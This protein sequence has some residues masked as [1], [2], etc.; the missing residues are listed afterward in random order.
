[1]SHS[2]DQHSRSSTHLDPDS[3]WE[4]VRQNAQES[5]SRNEEHFS[6]D[7]GRSYRVLEVTA[8]KITVERFGRDG[9]PQRK[10]LTRNTVV[11]MIEILNDHPNGC[12]RSTLHETYYVTNMLIDLHPRLVLRSGLVCVV[13]AEAAGDSTDA[14]AGAEAPTPRPIVVQ[15]EAVIIESMGDQPTREGDRDVTPQQSRDE[16]S[17][18]DFSTLDRKAKGFQP[19]RLLDDD[20]A[21]PPQLAEKYEVLE[22]LGRGGMGQ[23]WKVRDRKLG[24]IVALKLIRGSLTRDRKALNRFMT[25]ARSA[26]ALNH[27]NVVQLYELDENVPYLT[28]E[29]AERGDLNRRLNEKGPLSVEEAVKLTVQLADALR[30]AHTHP[31]R[32]RHRDIKPA[33]VLLAIGQQGLMIPKLCDFGLARMESAEGH[34]SSG[35]IV[36]TPDYMAPE[37][38]QSAKQ[39]SVL[40]DQW[41]L[42]ATLYAMLTGKSPRYMRES[43]IPELVREVVSKGLEDDPKDRFADV[44]AFAAA[45]AACLRESRSTGTESSSEFRRSDSTS[46]PR[47]SSGLDLA[48][49]VRQ[50]QESADATHREARRLIESD[51]DYSVAAQLLEDIPEHLRDSALFQRA[52]INRDRVMELENSIASAVGAMNLNGLDGQVEELLALQPDRDDMQEL[53]TTLPMEFSCPGCGHEM[54]LQSRVDPQRQARCRKCRCVFRI[55]DG[56]ITEAAPVTSSRS[57]SDS[58]PSSET[59]RTSHSGK[60]PE[61]LKSPFSADVAARSQQEWAESLDRPVRWENSIGIPFQLIPA[62]E[63]Q[64]GAPQGEEDASSDE[65]PQHSVRITRSFYLGIYPVTQAEYQKVMGKNPSNFSQ[66][67][68]E[69][70]ERFPVETVS[71]EDAQ[72]FLSALGKQNGETGRTYRLP[73]EAEWEYACRAGTAAPF[74]F[75]ESLN[76]TQAN[77]DGNY[78]YSSSSGPYLKRT[79]VVGSYAANPFGLYDTH[80]NVWEWCGDGFGKSFYANSPTDDPIGPSSGS[81]RVLRGGSCYSFAA[82]CRCASRAHDVPAYRDGSIGFRVLCEL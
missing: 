18:G 65:H 32:I 47:A 16:R 19:D 39:T 5:M 59:Q 49:L 31:E 76:G 79:S 82:Y 26:A 22:L 33:T 55:S 58:Q 43:R 77:C 72:Q 56:E 25:E 24:R 48:R 4:V 3:S 8:A 13:P 44:A 10:P 1:M 36:G 50:M 15:S 20:Q 23:V 7:H 63:F 74:W 53:L 34:T 6:P 21:L 41:S 9:R 52:T 61:L 46:S 28:M 37:Q 29:Y 2:A 54:R 42:A 81:S 62:G 78:P 12:E 40:S 45:L 69:E 68:G 17:D 14:D 30:A 75:G 67:S 73:T 70:T 38:R 11:R 66:V 64:M 57:V 51:Y 60:R 80:G 35:S 71:W 27:P